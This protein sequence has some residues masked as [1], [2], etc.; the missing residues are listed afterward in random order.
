MT[1]PSTEAAAPSLEDIEL[2]AIYQALCKCHFNRTEAAKV[3]GISRR[4]LIYKLH[5]LREQ[6][7]QVDGPSA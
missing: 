5:H 2:Q 1:L 4:S 7:Y 6:G 3:L